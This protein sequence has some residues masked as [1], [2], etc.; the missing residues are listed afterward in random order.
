MLGM[1]FL[2][3]MGHA[4]PDGSNGSMSNGWYPQESIAPVK[5]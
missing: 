3:Q 2:V 1:F 4:E 5:D